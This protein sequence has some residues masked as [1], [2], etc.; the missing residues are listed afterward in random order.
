M[1]DFKK[2][3]ELALGAKGIKGYGGDLIK[4]YKILTGLDRVD[5]GR[6]FPMVGGVQNQGSQSEDSG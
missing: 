4:T 3:L 1:C 2:K 6:M 5:A